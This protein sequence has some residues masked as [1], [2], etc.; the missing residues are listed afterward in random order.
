MRKYFFYN[1]GVGWCCDEMSDR[2]VQ[3][4]ILSSASVNGIFN[5]F[6]IRGK[7][8]LHINKFAEKLR[9]ANFFFFYFDRFQ[10]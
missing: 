4:L 2:V 10:R 9:R 5:C 6:S 8:L 7:N 1:I 3:Y